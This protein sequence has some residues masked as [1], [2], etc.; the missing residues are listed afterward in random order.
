MSF[1]PRDRRAIPAARTLLALAAAC[2]AGLA[3]VVAC[4]GD[5]SSQPP[6]N[7]SDATTGGPPIDVVGPSQEGG[8]VSSTFR[9]AHFAPN[10]GNI[11]FCYRKPDQTKLTGPVLAGPSTGL[12]AGRDGGE[13]GA[14]DDAAAGDAGGD[15]SADGAAEA[16]APTSGPLTPLT[17]TSY[18]QIEGSGTFEIVV[19]R[20]DATS[21]AQ[22]LATGKVTLDA[23]HL[24]TIAVVDGVID[25]D[26]AALD[27]GSDAGEDAST[28]DAGLAPVRFL[29]FVDD[30]A[31][32]A[33]RARIRTIHLALGGAGAT[34]LGPL[35]MTAV[36]GPN[37]VV[38]PLVE[39]GKAGRS[40]GSEPPVDAL[41]YALVS[42]VAPLT[43]LR[44]DELADSGARGFTTAFADL[45]LGGA[46]LHTA[47]VAADATGPLVVLCSDKTTIGRRM[48]CLKL[49]AER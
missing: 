21:C 26:A 4:G 29:G 12:D 22:P 44:V 46:S 45:G 19:V 23:G 31:I 34:S 39:P 43:A 7:A 6:A 15:A 25:A 36:S 3:V 40:S 5:D 1:T 13:A 24:A 2:L 47:F 18:L 14:D 8:V 35:R 42:P 37:P 28:P 10:L 16:A 32:D 30:P 49:P 17:V 33:T 38:A 20:G 27:G 41:G 48:A 9:L 11:D